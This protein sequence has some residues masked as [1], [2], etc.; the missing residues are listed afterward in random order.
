MPIQYPPKK[1]SILRCDYTIGFTKP[2]MVKKRPVLILSPAI[3]GRP[4]L[5][6][7]VALSTTP[8][9]QI[10]PYHM[11]LTLPTRLPYPYH[12]N[13]TMWV[14]GDMVNSVGFHRLDLL[15]YER[16]HGKRTY[17]MHTLPS[18]LLD[19]VYACVLHGLGLSYLTKHLPSLMIEKSAALSDD[20]H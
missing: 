11:E 8:P 19:H 18:A 15:R 1:G 7:V 9:D 16:N 13:Q 2:E 4:N 3:Q 12:E 20:P 10:M 5:C 14:K 17:Y 6:T